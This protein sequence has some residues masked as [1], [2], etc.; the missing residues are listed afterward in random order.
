MAQ[1]FWSR[2]LKKSIGLNEITDEEASEIEGDDDI[3]IVGMLQKV[4]WSK[5]LDKELRAKVLDLAEEKKR[6]DCLEE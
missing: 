5:V 4:Y 3:V 2:G 6:S 1:I